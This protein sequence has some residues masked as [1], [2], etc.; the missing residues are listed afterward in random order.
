[1]DAGDRQTAE[2]NGAATAP[3]DLLKRPY[4]RILTPDP[5]S[6]T[7]TAEILEFPGCIAEGDTPQEAYANL[8]SAAEAWIVAALSLGQDI[9][10]PLASDG[11]AGKVALRLPRSLHR[12]ASQMAKRDGTS[13]NQFLVAAI[14]ER[15]GAISLLARILERIPRQAVHARVDVTLAVGD[16]SAL[17]TSRVP[18]RRA[19]D[20]GETA[21]LGSGKVILSQATEGNRRDE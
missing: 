17:L 20:T 5:E 11:Y 2:R 4:A 9:P 14:A 21:T 12:T 10:Q 1:M 18:F 8:E 19:I 7:Y 3:A 6:G 15:V 16:T 13:L